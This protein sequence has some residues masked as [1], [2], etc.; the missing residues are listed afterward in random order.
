ME[1]IEATS[2]KLAQAAQSKFVTPPIDAQV[3]SENLDAIMKLD[4]KAFV[5][6]NFQNYPELYV[7]CLLVLLHKQLHRLSLADWVEVLA[8]CTTVISLL[9]V[10]SFIQKFFC[11]D[12][13]DLIKKSKTINVAVS[14][15]FVKDF[16][17]EPTYF[18]KDEDEIDLMKKQQITF[19]AITTRLISEGAM[20]L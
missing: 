8:S 9:S 19:D 7:H 6:Y 10:A 20:P 17:S 18:I 3:V 12:V 14:A 11:I 16:T 5:S 15:R 4:F 2:K 1:P 13:F